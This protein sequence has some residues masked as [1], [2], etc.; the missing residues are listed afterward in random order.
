MHTWEAGLTL[1]GVSWLVLGALGGRITYI[2]S[3]NV[4]HLLTNSFCLKLKQKYCSREKR[5]VKTIK[6]GVAAFCIE[7]GQSDFQIVL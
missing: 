4:L 1:G 3:K 6:L 5:Q 2:R 7:I